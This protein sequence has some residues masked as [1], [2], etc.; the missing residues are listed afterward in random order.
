MHTIKDL[1]VRDFHKAKEPAFSLTGVITRVT[2]KREKQTI[3]RDILFCRMVLPIEALS[4]D[5]LYKDRDR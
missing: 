4:S 3:R 5:Q 2:F 1:G